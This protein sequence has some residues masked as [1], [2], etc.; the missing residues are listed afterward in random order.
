MPN[1]ALFVIA[2]EVE[3]KGLVL[4]PRGETGEL[5]ISGP[6]VAAGYLGR[7]ELTA[8]R[9]LTDPWSTNSHDARLYRTGDPAR[10]DADGHVQCLGRA[11]DP[12]K[13][14]GFQSNFARSKPRCPGTLVLALWPCCCGPTKT[15]KSTAAYRRCCC[16]ENSVFG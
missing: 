12:V 7:P 3:E 10:I 1:Y 14:R 16:R 6:G 4:L 9:F 2:P 15:R 13:I 11:D 5:C 8:D